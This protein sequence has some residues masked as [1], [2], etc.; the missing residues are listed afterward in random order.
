M[1]TPGIEF[2]LRTASASPLFLL[3]YQRPRLIY[4]IFTMIFNFGPETNSGSTKSTSTLQDHPEAA[5]TFEMRVFLGHVESLA[6]GNLPSSFSAEKKSTRER[7]KK[8]QNSHNSEI[9][10]SFYP[11]SL[12]DMPK[13]QELPPE[14]RETAS[15]P[16][17]RP[18]MGTPWRRPHRN[19]PEQHP[20]FSTTLPGL[21][22]NYRGRS[23]SAQPG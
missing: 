21:D 7:E 16:A 15:R 17:S 13:T 5:A 2:P 1:S 22:Y 4:D 20:I 19:P 23:S 10:T 12:K 6:I 9:M 3:I 11:V 18:P 14:L 8:I